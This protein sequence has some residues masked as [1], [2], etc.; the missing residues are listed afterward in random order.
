MVFETGQLR[1]VGTLESYDAFAEKV[2]L[3]IR[4]AFYVPTATRRRLGVAPVLTRH[5]VL[6][7]A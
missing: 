5:E 3:R 4:T 2:G 6:R 7:N 1:E